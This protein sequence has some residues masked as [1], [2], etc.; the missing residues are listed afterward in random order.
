M[1]VAQVCPRYWP[2]IGGVEVHVE[3]ISTELAKRGFEVEV[4]TT[5]SSDDM[6]VEDEQKAIKIKRFKYSSGCYGWNCCL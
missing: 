2:Y 3:D 1:R 4:L 5:Y 6:L